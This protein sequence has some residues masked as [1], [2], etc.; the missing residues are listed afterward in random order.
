VQSVAYR[1]QFGFNSIHLTS[2]NL[3]GPG[4][5]F[6]PRYSHVI[7][8]LVQKVDSAVRS[9]QD[10]VTVWGTG[11]PTRDLLYVDDCAEAVVLAME[12]YDK[13]DPVNLGTGT[14]TSVRTIVEIISDLMKFKGRIKFDETMPN[15]QLRRRIDTSKAEREFGFGARTSIEEGLKK[16]VEWYLTEG[17]GAGQDAFNS[18][19]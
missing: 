8:A 13:S 10:N 6:H 18:I 12:R 9:G 5:K 11:T 17:P 15:G 14:E 7:P 16:T 3:Y 2:A 19:T 4:D 1:R